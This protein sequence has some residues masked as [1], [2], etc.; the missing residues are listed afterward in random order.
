MNNFVYRVLN[1]DIPAI[2]SGVGVHIVVMFVI[3]HSVQRAI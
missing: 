2:Y 1:A 3:R